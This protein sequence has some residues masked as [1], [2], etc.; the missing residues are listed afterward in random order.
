MFR[1]IQMY[2]YQR[3]ILWGCYLL[4]IAIFPSTGNSKSLVIE[5]QIN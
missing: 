4:F 5:S 1:F 2:D 3:N